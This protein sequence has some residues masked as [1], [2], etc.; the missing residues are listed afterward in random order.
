MNGY[1]DMA[2][3]TIRFLLNNELK[4]LT[5][6]N[7]NTSVLQYLRSEQSRCGTKEGCASGDCGACTTVIAEL[8][9]DVL[10]YKTINSCITLLPSL[11]GKQLITVED[12]K[13]G[14]S[15]HP[16]QQAMVDCHGSQCGFCTPGFV[17]RIR[18]RVLAA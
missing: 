6:S 17:R 13:D 4:T 5:D 18:F 9:G 12:L 15:L 7:P 14:N 2:D 16:A 10:R 11:H 8:N 3:K 1:R